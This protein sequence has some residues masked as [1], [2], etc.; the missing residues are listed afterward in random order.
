MICVNKI[1][2][3]NIIVTL[4]LLLVQRE[5]FP[6]SV[7]RIIIFIILASHIIILM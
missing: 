7:K 5:A 2:L 6:S 3:L 4:V 1:H